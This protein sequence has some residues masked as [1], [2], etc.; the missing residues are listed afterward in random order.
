MECR[1]SVVMKPTPPASVGERRYTEED[2]ALILNR[3]AELQ[4]GAQASVPRYSLADIQEIAAGAGISREHVASVAA[5]V[6]SARMHHKPSMLG[7]PSQFRFEDSIEGEV[8]DDVVAEL[9][10]TVRREVGPQ[11]KVSEALGAV[12]WHAR[13]TFGT[14]SVTIARRGGRTM[15][16]LV[17]TRTDSAALV[18]TLG[19]TGGV[20]G[21]MALGTGLAT[22]AGPIALLAGVGIAGGGAWVSMRATWRRFARRY[23]AQTEALGATLVATARRAVDEG[24]V[25]RR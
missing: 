11:G 7:A 6:G 12:E 13:D 2:L 3:A 1:F 8:T 20:L 10:D 5:S 18:G 16:S 19:G 4:E 17:S 15:I 23:A 25:L 21:A 22:I 24:R 9:L 14:T